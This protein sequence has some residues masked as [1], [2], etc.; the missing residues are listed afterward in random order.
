MKPEKILIADDSEEIQEILSLFIESEFDNPIDCVSSG[1]Q[2]IE[3]IKSN[4]YA[5]IIS[6]Y[7]MPN[8]NGAELFDFLKTHAPHIPFILVCGED[9]EKV[10]EIPQFKNLEISS[11]YNHILEKPFKRKMLVSLLHKIFSQKTHKRIK[12]SHPSTD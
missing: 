1:H 2:A 3:K 5:L 7:N 10:K 11:P 8:G 4:Q 6:D 12:L 9:V